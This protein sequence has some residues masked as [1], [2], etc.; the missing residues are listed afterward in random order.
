MAARRRLPSEITRLRTLP[1]DSTV[2]GFRPATAWSDAKRYSV[3]LF[4]ALPGI[5]PQ[6]IAHKRIGIR[7]DIRSAHVVHVVAPID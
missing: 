7:P 5:A 3:T 1:Q 4:Y 6:L 2:A